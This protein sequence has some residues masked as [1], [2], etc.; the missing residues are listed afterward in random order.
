MLV[1]KF[2]GA[3]V[4]SADAVR[5][6]GKII[7]SYNQN[8][9]VVLSAM[10][11]TTNA[12]ESICSSH[13][14][15]LPDAFTAFEQ[16]KEEHLEIVRELFPDNSN[17]IY[18]ELGVIFNKLLQQLEKNPSTNYGFEYDQIIP[19]GELLSTKIV[20]AYLNSNESPTE[21]VDIRYYL[22]TDHTYRDAKVDWTIS[23]EE[24]KRKF[25]FNGSH[26]LFLTQG[27]V[28][29]TRYSDFTTLGREGS[30]YTAAIL[31][32][33]LDAEKVIIWKDVP[34][35]LNAD[36]K[37]FDE[38]QKLSNI[39]YHEAIELAYYGATVIHPKT[40]KPLQNKNIPL[41]VKSFVD[42]NEEGTLIN[43]DTSHD[44]LISSFI[45]KVNQILISVSARDLSF[46]GE[47]CLSKIFD[48][49]AKHHVKVNM[50]QN[51]ALSFT[52]C[53]DNNAQKIPELI[54][55]LN[56]RY[57]VL[58]NEDVELVTIRHYNQQTIDRVIAK[59]EVIVEQKSRQTA[60][61]V[62]K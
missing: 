54:E 3:S 1:F 25:V 60:R 45:F 32:H 57:K 39:S 14:N 2:G 22:I 48:T 17:P 55:E 44:S 20:S 49:F 9:V 21:W 4:K 7:K 23:T 58:Y 34:G 27:F 59:R 15:Q 52:I 38:T 41:Y 53:V 47:G 31:A 56:A 6:I 40:L 61:F 50:M 13:F 16:L 37:W 36:P 35:V 33:I 30:D 11:K 8:I 26:K 24:I 18:V 42:P 5:N 10:G 62:I 43:H 12:L 28:G 46:I 19:F 51:S 29:G